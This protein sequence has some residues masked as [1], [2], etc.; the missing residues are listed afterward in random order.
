M[1]FI[2]NDIHPDFMA[3]FERLEYLRALRATL[4]S[5][6]SIAYCNRE[7][8]KHKQFTMVAMYSGSA[9]LVDI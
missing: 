7:I 5:E 6:T 9:Q 3:S 8:A 2:A 1:N 4:H